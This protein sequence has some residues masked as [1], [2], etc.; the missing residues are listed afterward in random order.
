V[1][2]HVGPGTFVPIRHEDVSQ[3]QMH[4]EWAEISTQSAEQINAIKKNGGRI[5]AVGTTATRTLESAASEDGLVKSGEIL[6]RLFVRPGYRFKV[7]NALITNFHLPK[8]TLF[9]LVCA[10]AGRD[11]ALQAYHDAIDHSYRFFSYG[12][13]CYFELTD[14]S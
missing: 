10:A 2:L 5:I 8:T 6:T 13:A 11:R 12:D 4:A 9:M 7:I 14:L 3:H 1:T